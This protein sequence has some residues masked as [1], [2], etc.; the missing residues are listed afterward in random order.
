MIVT[1]ADLGD[2]FIPSNEL[3]KK[4]KSATRISLLPQ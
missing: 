4:A 3:L 2:Q 1:C